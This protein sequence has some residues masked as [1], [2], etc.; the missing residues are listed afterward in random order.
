MRMGRWIGLGV[1]GVLVA[2]LLVVLGV[3]VQRKLAGDST[4]D[5]LDRLTR[6]SDR[7]AARHTARVGFTVEVKPQVAGQ[8][9][10]LTGTSLYTFGRTP[11][12]TSTF[13]SIAVPGQ[14]PITATLVRNGDADHTYAQSP[15]LLLAD[16]NKW[17]NTNRTPIEWPN[18]LADPSLEFSDLA[19]WLSP[20][21][22]AVRADAAAATDTKLDPV[23]GAPHAYFVR[24]HPSRPGCP[25]S[26]GR[27]ID[28]L[29]NNAT[30][31]PTVAAWYDDAGLLRRMVVFGG[32]NW[33][34]SKGGTTA[35]PLP[36]EYFYR[37][38]FTVSD[39]G[40]P[41]TVPQPTAA[42]IIDSPLVRL[43]R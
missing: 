22:E 33:D 15:A 43:R 28:N 9:A 38:T 31:G 35:G 23:T 29:F 27:R 4:D 24:C 21:D 7:L 14:A 41:V 16:P 32:A 13:T 5:I 11:Q 36:D 39:F 17:V 37:L 19:Q 34:R 26:F 25:P 42:Q 3:V 20:L 12:S 2:A 8:T 30:S 6:T 40:T 10:T 18:T 1:A